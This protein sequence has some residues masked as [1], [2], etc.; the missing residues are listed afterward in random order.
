VRAVRNRIQRREYFDIAM[1][2]LRIQTDQRLEL[3][4][5]TRAGASNEAIP[6]QALVGPAA[7]PTVAEERLLQL[8]LPNPELRRIIAPRLESRDF[9]NLVTAPI[10][11]ALLDLEKEDRE[12]SFDS[13]SAAI[14]NDTAAG[15]LLARLMMTE[16][17]EPFEDSLAAAESC[18]SALR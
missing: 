18:L 17:T 13:L 7:K 15:E 12:I 10:F 9:D 8:L 11:Q 4:Q 2:A 1:D 3:W 5:R 14:A 6:V 16:T